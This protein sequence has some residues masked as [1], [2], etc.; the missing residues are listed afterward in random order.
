MVKNGEVVKKYQ[1]DQIISDLKLHVSVSNLSSTS[2]ALSEPCL[3]QSMYDGRIKQ[4]RELINDV[5]APARADLGDAFLDH[6][7]TQVILRSVRQQPTSIVE[8]GE[9]YKI[10]AILLFISKDYHEN[11]VCFSAAMAAISDEAFLKI[12]SHR[13]RSASLRRSPRST[14]AQISWNATP[15]TKS[16]RRW[17]SYVTPLALLTVLFSAFTL[18]R[19]VNSLESPTAWI[20]RVA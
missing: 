16:S 12:L 20:T 15:P 19:H 10:L 1:V 5:L 17:E 3:M 14:T 18:L 9:F 11:N 6:E 7:F 13:S 2:D 4:L 8:N